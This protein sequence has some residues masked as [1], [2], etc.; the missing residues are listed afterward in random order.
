MQITTILIFL[1]CINEVQLMVDSTRQGSTVPDL[2][3]ITIKVLIN[4]NWPFASMKVLLNSNN[5][6]DNDI[7]C[8]KISSP[9]TSSS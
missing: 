6:D 1:S 4:Y 5:D 8:N 3:F 2:A 7:A 9:F